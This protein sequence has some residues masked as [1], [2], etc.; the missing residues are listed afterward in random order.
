M[1]MSALLFVPFFALLSY[2]IARALAYPLAWLKLRRTSVWRER[3]E[4]ASSLELL[5]DFVAPLMLLCVIF[6][7]TVGVAV[8]IGTAFA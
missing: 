5:F 6:G 2:T 8:W 4:S 3:P 7:G 1:E